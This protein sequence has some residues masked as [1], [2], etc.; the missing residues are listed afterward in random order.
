[1][2]KLYLKLGGVGVALA[3]LLGLAGKAS[4]FNYV[5]ITAANLAST[6]AYITNLFSDVSVFIWLAIGIPLGF[7]VI[8]RVISL[9]RTRA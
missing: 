5:E 8:K 6:T 4:A 1:M 3:C 7:Y 2:N 9:V